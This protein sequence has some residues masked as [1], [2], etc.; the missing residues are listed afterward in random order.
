M[1]KVLI[2]GAKGM[3]GAELAK[4]FAKYNPILWS[5]ADVDISDKSQVHEKIS[6]LVPD[7]I[8]N[9]AAYTNVDACEKNE[10]IA[11][12]V[13]GEAVGYLAEVAHRLNAILVHYSTDY[14][15]DG[16]KKQGYVEND[17]PNPIN[18]YGRS[19]LKGEQAILSSRGSDSDRGS[20]SNSG[21]ASSASTPS[22]NGILKY[23]I[24]RT[25][26]LY[27]R[28]GKNFVETML[29]LAK[30][31]QTIKVV[32]DQFGSPTY[33][34]DLAKATLDIIK[35]KK[36]YGIYHRTNDDQTSWYGFAKEIFSV[37]G[38]KASLSVCSTE[39][40]LAPAKRPKYS[41]LKSTKLKPMRTWQDALRDYKK[42]RK[43]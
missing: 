23:Y 28:Y 4:V 40:Y 12:K 24:I 21:I 16:R 6:K 26:W 10:E 1:D 20:V 9:S 33:A 38:I 27:G 13:N 11:T 17:K 32:N 29:S 30:K 34:P 35:S 15:F 42:F 36:P 25:S 43:I 8:I 14:V 41:V 22:R 19:K 18:A 39:E 3:L 7:V 2:I 5:R 31:A 37:F